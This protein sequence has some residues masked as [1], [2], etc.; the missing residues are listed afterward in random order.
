M[1]QSALEGYAPPPQE[2]FVSE[3][4]KEINKRLEYKLAVC[5]K[6]MAEFVADNIE[7]ELWQLIHNTS[8]HGFK[9]WVDTLST[10][11]FIGNILV[12]WRLLTTPPEKICYSLRAIQKNWPAALAASPPFE[13]LSCL[14]A[15]TF[16]THRV[17]H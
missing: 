1:L 2:H 8:L 14:A 16:L 13:M 12:H 10:H 4:K 17:V 7:T 9:Q 11:P 5:G 6:R 3:S 15:A